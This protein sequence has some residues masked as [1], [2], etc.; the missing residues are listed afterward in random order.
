M[1]T[2]ATIRRQPPARGDQL[3]DFTA[4]GPDG[5]SHAPRDAYQRRNLVLVFTH[6]ADCAAC[7]AFLQQLATLEEGIA[8]EAG[9]VLPIAPGSVT[10][11]PR[12][13]DDLDLP[14]PIAAD[15]DLDVYARYGLLD[16]AATPRAAVFIAD[17][18][19]T[20]FE[21]SVA[22]P[23]HTLIEPDAIPGWLEFIACRCS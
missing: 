6:G 10:A 5:R 3:P 1:A 13:R 17:R 8:A 21:S 9:T 11:A 12:L 2:G 14:F 19:G 16:A 20:V 23:D 15:P 4:P 22:E 7:H 18:Y